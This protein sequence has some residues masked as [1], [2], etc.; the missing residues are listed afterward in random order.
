MSTAEDRL[1]VAWWRFGKEHS[2]EDFRVNPPHVIAEHLDS[3]VALF[4]QTPEADWRWRQE[5]STL[6][7]ERPAPDS[8]LYGLDTR[9]YYLVARGLAV[10]ENIHIAEW[11]DEWRWYVHLAD[12]FHD[13]G[14]DAWIMQDLFCD[15]IVHE[16]T[17]RYRV[18]D[19]HDLGNALD[20]GLITPAKASEILRRTNAVLQAIEAGEFP[21]PEIKRGQSVC[22][23]L[24]W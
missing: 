4:R 18:L 21:F 5:D 10:I 8:W 17:R 14:R 24:G 22:R 20:I 13:E 15:V 11:D 6:I 23:G 3:K 19:L 12:I 7:V 1:L 2:E 9:I 16:D